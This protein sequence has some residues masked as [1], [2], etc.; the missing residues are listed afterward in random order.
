MSFAEE[1]AATSVLD[2]LR[3]KEYP[4]LDR[5]GEVYLDYTGA[6]V[7][8][9]AQLRAHRDRLSAR[10]YGNPHSV[11][12]SSVASTEL[13]ESARAAVLAY[14]NADPAEYAVIFTPNAT[15]ACRLV[16]ESYPFGRRTDLVLTFDNHNSV[17]GVREYARRAGAALR[18]VPAAP[19]DLRTRTATVHGALNRRGLFAYPA[20][21]NFTGVQHP[22]SWIED[23]HRAGYDVLLD[24]A[25][26]LPTNPLDLSQVKPDYVPISWYKVFGHPTGIGCLVA[27]RS[28]LARLRRPWFA[29]GT[30]AAVS[31]VGDWHQMLTDESGFEDGTLDFLNIPDVEFGLSWLSGIGIETVRRRVRALTGLLLDRLSALRHGNGAAMTRIYGP[32]TT[33]YRGGT[34]A[35]NFLD[36]DGAVVDERLVADEASE[37]RFSLRTGC[38]CNPGAGEGA[39]DIG[40]QRMRGSRRWG[41]RTIDDYLQLIGLPSGGAVR[42]SLGLMSNLADVERFLDFAAHTYRDRHVETAGLA[43]RLRC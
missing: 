6:G 5:G 9:L 17:N 18:Y 30:I 4:H 16:G 43:P 41:V 2:D 40:R 13:V 11:N 14:L 32:V 31:V 27:R 12:P 3:T 26:Y 29:G 25:A 8:S 36:P 23:A 21:S 38:F 7:Y 39:F 34:V 22:L 20:Q 10:V 37:Q 35:F 24:V 1:Y 28:A 42:V 15:G 33:E 19:P